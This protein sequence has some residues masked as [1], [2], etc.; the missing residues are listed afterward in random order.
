[1]DLLSPARA[2]CEA[3]FA[4][5]GFQLLT[6]PT[7]SGGWVENYRDRMFQMKSASK[8]SGGVEQWAMRDE[9]VCC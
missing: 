7:M 4:E 6:G 9:R 3:R 8:M 5:K 2:S 1:M